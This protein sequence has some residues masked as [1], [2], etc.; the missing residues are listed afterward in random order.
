M[1]SDTI[2]LVFTY[3]IAAI[4]VCGGGLML[5][6]TRLDPKDTDVAGLRLL[7]AGFIGAA[8]TW[9]FSSESALR[10]TRAS[11]SSQELKP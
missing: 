6:A 11:E 1:K 9:V 8:L 2:K 3:G 4:V 7:L 5:Y 10:A